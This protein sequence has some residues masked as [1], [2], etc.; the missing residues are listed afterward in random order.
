MHGESFEVEVPPNGIPTPCSAIRPEMLSLV[1]LDQA[2]IDRIAAGVEG[3][4]ANVRDI[5]PLAPLQE[6]ILF[7]HLMATEGDP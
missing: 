2:E 3:G 6:G 7:H 5:Y 1:E 4:A